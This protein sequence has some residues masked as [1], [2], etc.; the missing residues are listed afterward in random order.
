ML[1]RFLPRRTS[2]RASTTKRESQKLSCWRLESPGDLWDISHRFVLCAFNTTHWILR[3]CSVL[4]Y[5]QV[6]TTHWLSVW[7][8]VTL[9]S[10]SCWTNCVIYYGFLIAQLLN[11][12]FCQCLFFASLM[13]GPSSRNVLYADWLIVDSLPRKYRYWLTRLPR[14]YRY[15]LTIHSGTGDTHVRGALMLELVR[16]Q[17]YMLGSTWIPLVLKPW[18]PFVLN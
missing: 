1:Q 10:C 8:S 9:F 4:P 3:Q 12:L 18:F 2:R 7:F 11:L 14:K 5:V 16:L 13:F 6:N 15:W 17:V